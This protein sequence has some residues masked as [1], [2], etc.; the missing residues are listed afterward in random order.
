MLQNAGT[1]AR[2]GAFSN[3]DVSHLPGYG[4]ALLEVAAFYVSDEIFGFC[5]G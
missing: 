5:S 1:V 2:F 3:S 4:T